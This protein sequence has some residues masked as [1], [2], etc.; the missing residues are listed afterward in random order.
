MGYVQLTQIILKNI[1]LYITTTLMHILDK[2]DEMSDMTLA[3]P[4]A[5]VMVESL[6]ALWVF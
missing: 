2:W 1:G 6:V 3:V 5:G 4:M